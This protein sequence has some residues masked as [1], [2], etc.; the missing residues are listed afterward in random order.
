MRLESIAVFGPEKLTYSL[1]HQL[2][3][4]GFKVLTFPALAILRGRDPTYSQLGP[5]HFD[6]AVVFA[7]TSNPV[8]SILRSL[9]ELRSSL[10]WEGFFLA[11]V[12]SQEAKDRLDGTSLLAENRDAN[13][14]GDVFG[15]ASLL[16][17][18]DLTEVAT[19]LCSGKPMFLRAWLQLLAASQIPA[20]LRVIH[21]L[22]A[23]APGV[24]TR[25]DP[26][27]DFLLSTFTAMDW[28]TILRDP[29]RD[30]TLSNEIR[31]QC[32]D[33]SLRVSED[34]ALLVRGID[35]LVQR[36]WIANHYEAET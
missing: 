7:P 36:T 13:R 4:V 8:S 12:P 21:K 15:H 27:F 9:F 18:V 33:S 17:P 10:S 31:R 35:K 5:H 28:R 19:Q 22:K 11:L 34:L 29:H 25:E 26:E 30:T 20:L 24:L 3:V 23:A 14:F 32:Q 1:G 16:H 6:A 2:R